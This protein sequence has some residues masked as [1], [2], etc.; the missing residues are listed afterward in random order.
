[1][2]CSSNS[3]PALV[4]AARAGVGLVPLSAAWGDRESSLER[5]FDVPGMPPRAMGL[6]STAEA[7]KRPACLAVMHHLVER[8]ARAVNA[9]R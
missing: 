5:L 1:M 6:V 3:L 8:F 4:P 2:A 9:R 7:A